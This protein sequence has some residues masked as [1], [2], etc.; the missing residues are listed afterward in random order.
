MAI[1]GLTSTVQRTNRCNPSRPSPQTALVETAPRPCPSATQPIYAQSAGP[2]PGWVPPRS[3]ASPREQ[4][5]EMQSYFP[6]SSHFPTSSPIPP[7]PFRTTTPQSSP[8]RVPSTYSPRQRSPFS[9]FSPPSNSTPISSSSVIPTISSSSSIFSQQ[10]HPSNSLPFSFDPSRQSYAPV[11][12]TAQL[13]YLHLRI[14]FDLSL[15]SLIE[16][17]LRQFFNLLRTGPLLMTENRRCPGKEGEWIPFYVITQFGSVKSVWEEW[18]QGK[19][20]CL[21]VKEIE[22]IWKTKWRPR[23]GSAM[24]RLGGEV[25]STLTY[26]TWMKTIEGLVTSLEIETRWTETSVVKFLDGQFGKG[27]RDLATRIASAKTKDALRAEISRAAQRWGG[28]A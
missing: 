25:G 9:P 17:V 6:T 4:Q 13:P 10:H 15:L 18:D 27:A 20:G 22:G 8:P 3:A 21:P 16:V 14:S 1:D 2:P 19:E 12:N 26:V 11:P 24:A 28:L 7:F 23:P 5:Q